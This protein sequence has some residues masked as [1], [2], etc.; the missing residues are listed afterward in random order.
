MFDAM[1][2][3]A[4]GLMLVGALVAV[5]AWLAQRHLPRTLLVVL[6]ALVFSAGILTLVAA[7][8]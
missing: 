1:L 5:G 2:L 7:L 8:E 3:L 6:G 4:A